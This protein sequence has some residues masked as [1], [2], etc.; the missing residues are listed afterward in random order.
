MNKNSLQRKIC[1]QGGRKM[2]NRIETVQEAISDTSYKNALVSLLYHLADDNFIMGY[3]GSEWLGLAPHLEADVAFCSI[4]QDQMGHAALFYRLLEDLG[5]GKADDLS[6]LRDSEAFQNAVLVERPNGTGDFIVNP[7][8][9]WAYAVVRQYFFDLFELI[10]ISSLG[11]S[12]YVP[13][14][15]AAT[16]VAREKYYH[17]LHGE[18]WFNQLATTTDTARKKLVEAIDKVWEDIGGLFQLGEHAQELHQFGLIESEDLLRQRFIDQAK[19]AFIE[20]NIAWPGDPTA[21]KLNGRIGEHSEDLST[22]LAI[23][24]EVYRQNPAANW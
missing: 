16:K 4:A 20:A 6:H 1:Y 5:E 2:E 9:D 11:Q 15:Q 12:S 22:A 3:R 21:P 14:A 24:S 10:R 23:I 8:Y 17:R 7:Q 13:L 18:T 19:K